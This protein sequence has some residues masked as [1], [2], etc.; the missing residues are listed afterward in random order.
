MTSA[1]ASAWAASAMAGAKTK[2]ANDRLGVGLIG[3][4]GRGGAHMGAIKEMAE[5]DG[6]VEVVALCDVYRPRIKK[7]AE[8][9]GI[10]KPKEYMDHRELLAD[11]RVDMVCIATPDHHHGHQAMDAL[12][13]GKHVY[14]EKPVTHWRQ[15]GVIKELAKVASE[16]KAV[17]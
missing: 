13:A 10:K 6:S 3:C 1:A 14:C 8:K 7:T 11:K 2:S 9:F 16:S 12:K 5:R 4:G 17:F 15:F